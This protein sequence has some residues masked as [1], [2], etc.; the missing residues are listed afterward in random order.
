MNIE[1]PKILDFITLKDNADYSKWCFD[2]S[3]VIDD[4]FMKKIDNND[5]AA[6]KTYQTLLKSM[7]NSGEPAVI[8]SNNKN[9]ICDCCAATPLKPSEGLTLGHIN[10]AKFYNHKT[11]DYQ[12]LKKNTQLLASGLKIVDKNSYIV[13]LGYQDFLNKMNLEYGSKEANSILENSLK[14]IQET[15]H[16]NG[17]KTAI[18]PTGTTS[19][20]LK[21]T[22]SIEPKESNYAKEIETMAIAQK[23]L[24]G[25]ISKTI[26]L[27]KNATI[28]DID[29]II[30][31]S[32]KKKLKGISIFNK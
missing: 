23:Y 4:E 24:D 8:F 2:L 31:M 11:L 22:P 14:I 18:S 27:D 26:L 10:L 7:K 20:F 12:K 25:N 6:Q 1:H 17:L 21:T 9:Y 13:I 5:I 29:K 28:D 19:R 16:K 15:A 3:V 30:K 32:Y